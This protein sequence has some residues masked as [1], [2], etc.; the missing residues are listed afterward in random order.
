M[1][2]SLAL[3]VA[4]TVALPISAGAGH[5][6]GGGGGSKSSGTST[7]A[8]LTASVRKSAGGQTERVKSTQTVAP[9]VR[10][11]DGQ[12]KVT[13]TTPLKA[14]DKPAPAPPK[15]TYLNLEGVKGESSDQ[16]MKD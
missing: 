3:I 2:I 12:L 9:S 16:N 6:G 7:K 5:S 10:K 15:D 8:A 13:I 14:Q 4:A 1:R 11:A